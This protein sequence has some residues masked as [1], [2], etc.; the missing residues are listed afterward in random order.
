MILVKTI[1]FC[2]L[3]VALAVNIVAWRRYDQAPGTQTE[4]HHQHDMNS[5]ALDPGWQCTNTR[6][7]HAC[8][9]NVAC[10]IDQGVMI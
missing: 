4:V 3:V 1:V 5:C 8:E 10:M 2:A 6:R 7:F 9:G